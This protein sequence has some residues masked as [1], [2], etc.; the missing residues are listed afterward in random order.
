MTLEQALQFHRL[1]ELDAAEQA[2]RQFLLDSPDDSDAMHLLGVLQ[3]QRG[4]SASAEQSIRRAIELEPEQ[5]QFHLSLG[6]VQMHLGNAEAARTSFETAL[7][8]DPNS[9]EAH[10]VL[11]H[12]AMQGGDAADAEGRFRIGRRVNDDDPMILLGLG[13]LYL[14][15]NDS[16]NAVKFLSRAAECKPD[17]P[18]IQSTLGQAFF[19][20]GAFAFAE[21]AFANALTQ[22][23]EWA[24]TGLCLARAKLRQDKL[25]QAHAIF[26]ALIA[27]E[28]QLFGANA[29]L[30]DIARKQGRIAQAFRFYRRA[31]NIDPGSTGAANSCA[32]C[33]EHLGDIPAAIAFLHDAL[34]RVPQAEEL[35]EPLAQLLERDG[36]KLEAERVRDGSAPVAAA[37]R[38]SAVDAGGGP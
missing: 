29:G 34:L 8:L 38:A 5:A 10:A 31:L 26:S 11:G 18:T 1:G 3:Q 22:R 20:Q 32:W 12:L 7:R 14:S 21:K 33:L 35:R 23:P 6:G 4:D 37:S 2:Y 36:R 9:A 17:D 16:A 25:E 24:F 27:G 28:Q 19:L 30:G 15:R 13:H